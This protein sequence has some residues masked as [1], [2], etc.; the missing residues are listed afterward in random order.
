MAACAWAGSS[1]G[2]VEGMEV[3]GK[4]FWGDPV[5]VCLVRCVITEFLACGIFSYNFCVYHHFVWLTV[6]ILLLYTKLLV[7]TD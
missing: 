4:E 5:Q 7:S 1:A 3:I 6:K 2:G